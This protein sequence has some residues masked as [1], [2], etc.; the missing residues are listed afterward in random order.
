VAAGV[1]VALTVLSFGICDAVAAEAAAGAA[2]LMARA[3]AA[4]RAVVLAL[5]EA[6]AAIRI[7]TVT[8]RTWGTTVGY[9][10][11]LTL[12]RLAFSPAGTGALGVVGSA[13]E[14]D[15][16]PWTSSRRSRSARWRKAGG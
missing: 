3:A 4:M 10:A 8:T 6:G 11:G 9:T 16:P 7:L 5:D 12:P 2:V 15:T 1:E 14:G 13:A